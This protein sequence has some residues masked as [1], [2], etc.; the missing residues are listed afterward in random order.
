MKHTIVCGVVV[1]HD[2]KL[3][4]IQEKQPKVYKQWW[5]PAG[6]LDEGETLMK[7]AVREAKE[8]TGYDVKLKSVLTIVR[9]KNRPLF[10]IFEAEI[11]SGDIKIDPDEILDVKWMPLD[12]VMNLDIREPGIMKVVLNRIKSKE[13]YP[14]TILKE[15]K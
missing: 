1:V 7:G 12:E 3:L 2:D 13:N 10:A 6:K 11:I 14:L 15:E 8:E 4:L 9:P 5:L